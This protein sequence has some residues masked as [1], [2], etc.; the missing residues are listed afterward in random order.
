MWCCNKI[1]FYLFFSFAIFL[2][3]LIRQSW[4]MSF[5]YIGDWTKMFLFVEVNRK[6]NSIMATLLKHWIKL[7]QNEV[8][9]IA[10]LIKWK[11]N[12][13]RLLKT[14]FECF[15]YKFYKSLSNYDI[16][17]YILFHLNFVAYVFAEYFQVFC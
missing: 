2:R 6:S 14:E 8:F 17:R 4:L 13:L 1:R 3:P 9:C 12:H 10:E 7:C 16:E 11:K 15:S 5:K